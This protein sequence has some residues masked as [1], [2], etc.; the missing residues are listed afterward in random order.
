MS[1]EPP[2]TVLGHTRGDKIATTVL[3]GAGGLV[4]FLL[5]PLL[6]GWLSDVP[7]VPFKGPLEWI[8]SFDQPWAWV[9]RP[10]I[11]LVVGVVAAVLILADQYRLEVGDEAV[12]VHHGEDAR[13][14]ARDQVAAVY[15]DRKKVVIDGTDGRRLFE[16]EVEAR[17]D[18]V[19]QAFTRHGY[20][21]EGL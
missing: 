14:I 1:V 8:G 21:W 5:A 13:K 12:V 6:A 19:A 16:H 4:L 20:P 17:R 3:F 11:G 2:T 7:V 10:A 15:R 18:Q 9:A